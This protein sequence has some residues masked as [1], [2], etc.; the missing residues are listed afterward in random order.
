MK[1]IYLAG[2]CE[3]VRKE[4]RTIW[5]NECEKWFKAN[6][7]G[8]SVINPVSYFDYDGNDHQSE[9]EVFRFF[10]R[11]V[12]ESDI[13]LVNL[14]NIRQSVGTICELAFAYKK[15]IPI[16][17]FN[18]VQ[19]RPDHHSWID[20]MLDRSFIKAEDAMEYIKN[21]YG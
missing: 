13:V 19:Y 17:G 7:D 10:R 4:E 2:C 12:E 14:E 8:F 9:S 6:T 11:K 3:K 1:K 21:Y 5:R 16:I 18:S 20:I 15:D